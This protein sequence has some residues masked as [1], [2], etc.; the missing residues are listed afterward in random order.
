MQFLELGLFLPSA[1]FMNVI[2]FGPDYKELS[3]SS[4]GEAMHE[5]SKY[6]IFQN[7]SNICAQFHLPIQEIGI[8]LIIIHMIVHR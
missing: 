5:T 8:A 2:S 6:L 4:H 1:E 3:M 7:P